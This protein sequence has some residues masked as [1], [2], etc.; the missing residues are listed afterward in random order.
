MKTNK[1]RK[2]VLVIIRVVFAVLS[3]LCLFYYF[4]IRQ[5]SNSVIWLVLTILFAGNLVWSYAPKRFEMFKYL[6]IFMSVFVSL[7]LCVSIGR[8]CV[9]M[10]GN[11]AK[12]MDYIIVLGAQVKGN[13]MSQTLKE[14][15]NTAVEY[16]LENKKTIAV[17]SGGKGSDEQITEAKAMKNY[18]IENGVD[19]SRIIEEDK[20]ENTG[21]NI[22]NS[23]SIISNGGKNINDLSIGVVSSSYHLKRARYIM[24]KNGADTIHCIP[25]KTEAY[26]LPHYVVREAVGLYKEYMSFSFLSFIFSK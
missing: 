21:E 8:V 3:L 11:P 20:S 1:T 13:V 26:T 4:T 14:R 22:R 6:F 24:H 17:V 12:D 23:L 7:C 19:P 18:M 15:C 16:M 5:L 2:A 10:K 9:N 25:A